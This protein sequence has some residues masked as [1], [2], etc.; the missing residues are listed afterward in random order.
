MATKLKKPV[1]RE[2]IA[3]DFK[4][5]PLIVELLPNGLIS[6]RPKGKRN[7][8]VISLGHCHMLSLILDS[9]LTY[10]EKIKQYQ[11]KRKLGAKNL[12]RPKKHALPY[13]KFY[14]KA[15]GN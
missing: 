5:N 14:Y 13:S 15:L 9:E 2:T 3:T 7:K 6:F 11:E 8:T 12:R 10:K 1:I 4:G